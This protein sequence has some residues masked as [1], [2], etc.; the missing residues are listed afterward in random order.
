MMLGERAAHEMAEP[1]QAR[2]GDAV[3]D[4]QAVTLP[5]HQPSLE[6]QG[7]MLARVGLR[8]AREG[9][10]LLD[11][12]VPLEESLEQRQT[13]GIA[14]SAEALSDDLER[15]PG[16]GRFRGPAGHAQRSGV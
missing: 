12:T 6:E 11:G 16:Q 8:R 7:Q 13:R 4:E 2:I 15:L 3:A 5:G 1:L 9:A 14:E 10:Q